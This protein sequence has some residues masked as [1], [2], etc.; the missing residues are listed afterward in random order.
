MVA[1]AKSTEDAL[2]SFANGSVPA[3]TGRVSMDFTTFAISATNEPTR[4]SV[5]SSKSPM[6]Q[7]NTAGFAQSRSTI[8]RITDSASGLKASSASTAAG[9]SPMG[10]SMRADS[11][12]RAQRLMRYG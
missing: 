5:G 4:S 3:Y 8:S 9:T 7:A 10:A 2:T 12:Y 11:P 6:P 1:A